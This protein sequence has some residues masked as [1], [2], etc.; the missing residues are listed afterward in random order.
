MIYLCLSWLSVH[1]ILPER[2]LKGEV[3]NFVTHLRIW[4]W[5]ILALCWYR[6]FL[7]QPFEEISYCTW[8]VQVFIW[9]ILH[10][11]MLLLAAQLPGCV[12]PAGR[13]TLFLLE[14]HLYFINWLSVFL[15][16]S[17]FTNYY[18][19][20]PQLVCFFFLGWINTVLTIKELYLSKSP[21]I[22]YKQFL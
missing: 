16:T 1:W 8:S 14:L 12:M 13:L 22:Q 21:H 5:H 19:N 6:Y 7:F 9:C 18:I 17:S 11:T 15:S 2:E 4:N 20:I 10:W 3:Y